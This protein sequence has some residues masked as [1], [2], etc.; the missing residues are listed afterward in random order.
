MRLLRDSAQW[1]WAHREGV[2]LLSTVL[3]LVFAAVGTAGVFYA[4]RSLEL[5]YRQYQEENFNREQGS[6]SLAWRTIADA[7][8]QVIEIGQSDAVNFLTKKS[9]FDGHI[10]LDRSVLTI[11]DEP[12]NQ[13]Y[14]N[15]DRST[16]CG[17][18][19]YVYITR[20]SSIS[21][22]HS[23]LRGSRIGGRLIDLFGIGADFSHALFYQPR[24][25]NSNLVAANLNSATFFGGSFEKADF[26][27]ADLRN[28]R[29]FRGKEGAGTVYNDAEFPS[30][31]YYDTYS[32]DDFPPIFA[33]E[34]S[35][36]FKDKGG[37]DPDEIR[38]VDFR[39]ARF[40]KAEIRGADLSNS[41]IDQGT[42][43][44]SLR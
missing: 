28:A 12:R 5:Q 3:L 24:I 16:L 22:Q 26:Q 11:Y 25:A 7:N 20:G 13:I 23:L 27:G 30:T 33:S 10:T 39:K 1:I 37:Y 21:L 9:R 4:A 40:L 38:L 43:R 34:F 31:G 44:R 15:L 14:I 2:T 41:N 17:T 36:Y 32:P 19:L 29:T 42:S 8:Q 35:D 18:N 6:V